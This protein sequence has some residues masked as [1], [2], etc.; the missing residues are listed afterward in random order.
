MSQLYK[1][2]NG[3]DSI[4]GAAFGG[5]RGGGGGGGG[6]RPHQSVP[7]TAPG[8]SIDLNGNGKQSDEVLAALG[9]VACSLGTPTVV[10]AAVCYTAV[11]VTYGTL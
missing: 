5:G 9:T 3:F 2:V 7:Y 8:I 4:S 1:V 11:A 6:G 10:G